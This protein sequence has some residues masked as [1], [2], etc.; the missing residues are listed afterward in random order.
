MGI[1]SLSLGQV[2]RGKPNGQVLFLWRSGDEE[3]GNAT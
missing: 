1:D 2:E 3:A